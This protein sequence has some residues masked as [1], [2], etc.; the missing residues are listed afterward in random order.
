[1]LFGE[2]RIERDAEGHILFL[3]QPADP[4]HTPFDGVLAEGFVDDI[5]L[6]V[7][8]VGPEVRA[9]IL[10]PDF[11][12]EDEADRDLAALGPGFHRDLLA[13]ETRDPV[14]ARLRRRRRHE[15]QHR[16]QQSD[17]QSHHHASPPEIS[18]GNLAGLVR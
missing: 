18:R 2:L 10:A 4:R 11:D 5:G 13:R 12:V 7:R 8:H 1:M 3:E 15:R 9:A 16:K 14:L 6:A 17:E